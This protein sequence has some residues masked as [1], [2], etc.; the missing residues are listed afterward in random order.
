MLEWMLDPTIWVGLFSL[1][2]LEIVLGIDNLVFIAILADKLPPHQR[3]RA[4]Q[5]GLVLALVMRLFLLAGISWM[6]TL[7]TPL[8]EILGKAFS[9]RDLI[10]LIGGL[11][12]LFKGTTELDERL[13]GSSH[14]SSQGP[15]LHASF[16]VVVTQIVVLDAV[17]S[18]DSVITAIG[19][20][21]QLPVMMAAVTI[22]IGVMLVAS[23][24]LTKFVNEHPTVVILC[25][26][27]LLMIGLTLVAESF[28]VEIPKGYLYAAMGFSV[29]IEFLNQVARFKREK[30][31]RKQPLR[32]RTADAV[33]KLLGGREELVEGV[34]VPAVEAPA[35]DEER[36][37][38][39][40]PAERNMIRS[41]LRLADAPIQ[42]QMTPRPDIAWLDVNASPEKFLAELRE[43]P[44]SRFLICDGQLDSFLGVAQSRDLLTQVLSGRHLTLRDVLAQPLIVPEGMSSLDALEALRQHPVPVA[45]VVDEYGSVMGLVTTSDLLAAIAGE[46]FDTVDPDA[47]PEVVDESSWLLEGSM[48]LDQLSDLLGVNLEDP[49]KDY[50][51]LAGFMLDQFQH[52]PQPEEK[53]EAKGFEFE[54]V[55]TE[56]LRIHRVKITRQIKA[57]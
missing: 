23:K 35:E 21:N 7:T 2:L 50:Y 15:K 11:F 49:A 10:L 28:G 25:L 16:A 57:E 22:A 42:S 54:V 39:F 36:E 4:R 53:F 6:V 1:I 51:T 17:F 56:G 33:W 48:P 45:V 27:F 55:S 52:M 30:T 24:P 37:E 14:H 44:Y 40:K 26:C 13:E 29:M 3:D 19:M 5:I 9:G 12:L 20:V 43:H 32:A 41:V 31:E 38:A 47:V 34:L 46:L 18:I 8:F